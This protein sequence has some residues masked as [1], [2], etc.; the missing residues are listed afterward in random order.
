MKNRKLWT[1]IGKLSFLVILLAIL[2][3]S[4]YI[5]ARSAAATQWVL[6]N[7]LDQPRLPANL[8]IIE[9]YDAFVLAEIPS[10][11]LARLQTRYQVEPLAERTLLT[12]SGVH[13][14][15]MQGEPQI[16]AGLRSSASDPYFLIQFYAPVKQEWLS[17]LEA[18]GV[19]FLGYQPNYTY[20]VRMDPTLLSSVRQARAV[21]WVG[22]YH[23]AY[24][25]ASDAELQR[26]LSYDGKVALKLRAL[27]GE[28]LAALLQ[29]MEQ[30]GV[31]ADLIS[32]Q[33]PAVIRLWA[34]P[35]QTLQLAALPGVYRIEP[36]ILPKL[37]NDRSAYVTNTWNVWRAARNGLL[38]DLMGEGQIA[39]MV[40]SGMDNNSVLP[41]INDF[42]SF[43]NGVK[44]SRV[45]AALP[46]AGCTGSC[47]CYTQDNDLASGHGTHVAGSILGNGYNSLLQQGLAAQAQNANPNYDYAF[48][49]GQAPEARLAF[50][51]TAGKVYTNEGTLCGLDPVYNTWMSLYDQGARN[52]NNSWGSNNNTYSDDAIDADQVM[53]ERQ[54]YLILA[55]A[56]NAGPGWSTAHRP[57][58]AKNILTV[59]AAGNHRP[60]WNS[61]DSAML[62]TDFSGRGPVGPN[63]DGRYKPDIVAPGADILSTRPTAISNDV[64]TMWANE[65]GDGDGDGHLDYWWSGGTSMS[66]PLLTGAATIV[67]DFLQDIQGLSDSTPPSAALI[68][69]FLLNGAVDMG[70]GYE[71]TQTSPY[72]GRNIQGWGMVNIEQSITPRAPRSYFYEDFTN[73]S[74]SLKQSTLGFSASGQYVDYFFNVQ[75][76]SEPLKVT[77]TWTDRQAGSDSFAVNNLELIVIAPNGTQYLGNVFS[78]SWSIPGGSFDSRNNTEAV[79]L[80]TPTAGV[81]MV[82][83]ID[84]SHGGGV[85]PFA[86]I[87]SGGL[88]IE[89][90]YTRTCSFACTGL[91]RSGDSTQP[92]F[93][94]IVPLS[95]SQE[96]LAANSSAATTLRLTNWGL[97]PDSYTLSYN[98]TNQAGSPVSGITVTFNVNGP[99]ALNVGESQNIEAA[100]AVGPGVPNGAYDVSLIAASTGS[101][102]RDTRVI[103]LNV[104]PTSSLLNTSRATLDKAPQYGGDFWG[105]GQILWM[106][107]LSADNNNNSD[108]KIL[109]QCSLDG[110]QTW[111]KTGQV[112][113]ND[114]RYY[115]PPA[116]AGSASGNSVTVVWASADASGVYAR[117]WTRSNGCSGT[118]GDMRILKSYSGYAAVSDPEVIY[119][120]NN[121]ILT[122]WFALKDS[123]TVAGVFTSLSE[124]NGAV[125]KASVAVPDASANGKSHR[126]P[127]F[128]L[129][130]LRNEVWM[131]YAQRGGGDYDRN[132][133]LKR[134]DGDT[135]TW[136]ALGTRSITVANTF[137]R[138]NHP[139]IAY[140]SATDSLWVTWSRYPNWAN[141]HAALYYARSSGSLPDPTFS[142]P[143]TLAGVRIAEPY[144]SEVVG[145]GNFTYISYLAYDDS[146]RG[147]NVYLLKAPAAGGAPAGIQ[148]ASASTDAVTLNAA[149]NAGRPSLFWL[150]TTV[151]GSSFTGPTLLYS[152]NTPNYVAP[153]FSGKLGVAQTLFNLQENFDLFISQAASQ[154]TA[155]TLVNWHAY[156]GAGQIYLAWNTSQEIGVRGFNLYRSDEITGTVKTLL[157]STIIPARSLNGP[158]TYHYSD[159]FPAQ[160]VRYYYWLEV[161]YED[162][163]QLL[164]PVD[165]IW[166]L[167]VYNPLIQ[168]PMP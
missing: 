156:P 19:Q 12:L 114:G 94:S 85:Q 4:I 139:A 8:R 5:P 86:L 30:I 145:D 26:A 125:W 161:I 56:G 151:N 10:G 23:P 84:A 29:E 37:E 159:A 64:V 113:Q 167:Q 95:G 144:P 54:D 123:S 17:N 132:I 21:Q 107:Y 135:N 45:V 24:R 116:I 142:T 98:V 137:E 134:W 16:A 168:R 6:I 25:L 20:I 46:G 35:E 111:T 41:L 147:S 97:H 75:T 146:L 155:L 129:D 67:R 138:E 121:D 3:F 163:T 157:N 136:D 108:S 14:D 38:Q 31:S 57:G 9:R 127:K 126:Y 89:P 148:Q 33:Q 18:L 81:W 87:V 79:Y 62:I 143:Y 28:N 27:P 68:K 166:L 60:Q 32:S 131:V 133:L 42:Y 153:D 72:G 165:A 66:T 104:I 100:I 44:T 52:V 40:D 128:A 164:G 50:A 115:M 83:V 74:S 92:Y 73:I 117:T 158:A 102:T 11:E 63:T 150:T 2:A 120:N 82:R 152:K 93:P 59:G 140:V 36:Y 7:T 99:L 162:K 65:N 112:D 96:H 88:G 119:D 70:Y 118:W 58:T 49:I 48:G 76:A 101:V 39:G 154:P 61:S 22:A 80:K 51:H 69:A 34:T 106:A 13:F 124:D 160:N 103:G 141:T 109:T 47:I 77:L 91:G 122:A 105:S 43:A 53:W 90:S 1:I 15:T 149:G 110:G 55:A 130:T 71:A 78:G